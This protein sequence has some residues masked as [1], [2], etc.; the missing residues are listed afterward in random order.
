VT[1][2]ETPPG[3]CPMNAIGT[4]AYLLMDAFAR[5][6]VTDVVITPGSRST[7][8]V[9]AAVRH[10]AMRCTSLI[11][12][13]V[14]AFH[15]LGMAK[16]TG[17]PTLLLCTS[18]SAPAHY[19]PAL[20]EASQSYV[21]I[22]VLSA[23]RPHALQDCGAPQTVDQIRLFGSFARWFVD[24]GDPQVEPAALRA[25]RRKAVQ[26]VL[27]A[28]H[29]WPG[30]VHVNARASKPLEPMPALPEELAQATEAIE[31]LREP[32]TRAHPPELRIAVEDLDAVAALLAPCKR[33]MIVC[34]PAPLWRRH[35]R[36]D[37]FRFAR[38]TGFALL[39][40]ATSQARFAPE[41]DG[42]LTL[43][44]FDTV[45]RNAEAA[46]QIEPDIIIQI[47]PAPTSGA[48]DR[49]LPTVRAPRVVI[50]PHGWQDPSSTAHSVV[51]APVGTTLEALMGR[52]GAMAADRSW[53]E[54]VRWWDD[55]AWRWADDL[56]PKQGSLSEASSVRVV[57][58]TLGEGALLGLGNSL[59]VRLV[60]SW[61]PGGRSD[62]AVFAQRGANGIDGLISGFAGA[63]AKWQ[64]PG[65][66]IVGDVS[67]AHDLG[68][69][70]IA[71]KAAQ[72]MAVVVI[73]NGGGRIFEQLPVARIDGI[74]DDFG[75]WTTPPGVDF[76][77]IAAGYGVAH[78]RVA[79]AED[80]RRCLTDALG[81]PGCTVV[82][83][84]VP[85]SDAVDRNRR[86]WAL[87]PDGLDTE[88]RDRV[89]DGR[90]ERES[91]RPR[92]DGWGSRAVVLLH[93]FA[94]GPASWDRVVELLPRGSRVIRPAL[95]GHGT[96]RSA[97][98]FDEEVDR[99]AAVLRNEGVEQALLCGYS[100]GARVALGVLVRRGEMFD[101]AVLIGAHPGLSTAQ[102]R[103][104][105]A[106]WD[107]GWADLLETRGIGAFVDAWERLPIFASQAR[108]AAEVAA[109]Q[110]LAR[111][112][113]D[114][115]GLAVAMRVLGLARMPD[116]K[117]SLAGVRTPV[118]L[119]AGELDSKFRNL[120]QAMANLMPNAE[121]QVVAGCGHNVVLEDPA[122][123]AALLRK[124]SS[125]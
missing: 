56:A 13:R 107:D 91:G 11:D 30:P 63:L 32:L 116:W 26:A 42:V 110:R 60:D 50:A 48:F 19:L 96:D 112:A 81:A 97:R 115:R 66:L 89:G 124:E 114:A 62:I 12:E 57:V 29:P 23:D 65:V 4:W 34:G 49:W 83:A 27:T 8:Y 55:L 58:E 77:A 98:T 103:A 35:E 51:S 70:W 36:D 108:L 121:L 25:L 120:A 33:G 53:G 6:G 37:V 69:L 52:I 9:V 82:E 88:R 21:P 74:D 95:C 123:V 117:G 84:M 46:R 22:I 41:R 105:R 100:L 102:E 15:A 111:L 104:E 101:R 14:A 93:G 59:P 72:P 40:E 5:C 17:R 75:L 64:R 122:A 90:K 38:T 3:V 78:Q 44:A 61:C 86:L 43:D 18:G 47:G 99:I 92:W 54:R 80:L 2:A 24:L 94:S 76:G 28:Q 45:L 118:T 16:A 79:S 87:R 67:A 7:P 85:Q 119:V 39:A 68:G 1:A 73:N 31:I 20:I 109:S 125:A 71:R 113:M 10:P 106:A